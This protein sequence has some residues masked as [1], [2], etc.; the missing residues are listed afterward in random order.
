MF[1]I[2]YSLKDTKDREVTRHSIGP[3]SD[4]EQA[5]DALQRLC[6]SD[7]KG[8]TFLGAHIQAAG[9]ASKEVVR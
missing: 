3:F 9:L 8:A 6:G 4:H 1:E 5:E 7:W 2:V